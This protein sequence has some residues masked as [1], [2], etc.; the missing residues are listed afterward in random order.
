[1]TEKL[2]EVEKRLID[3]INDLKDLNDPTL[4][5]AVAVV[6]DALVEVYRVRYAIDNPS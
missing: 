4:A 3:S 6:G 5:D 1:M 2:I